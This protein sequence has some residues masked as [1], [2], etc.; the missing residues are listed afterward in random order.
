M[1]KLFA[2]F[3]GWMV[4]VVMWFLVSGTM[5]FVFDAGVCWMFGALVLLM[6]LFVC[7]VFYEGYW[8]LWLVWLVWWMFFGEVVWVVVCNW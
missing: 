3:V 4:L 7:A 5:I 2:V 6:R 8:S 1:F